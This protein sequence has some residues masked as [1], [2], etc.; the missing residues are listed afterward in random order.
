MLYSH[1]STRLPAIKKSIPEL[2]N[3]LFPRPKNPHEVLSTDANF[4]GEHLLKG[5]T[6]RLKYFFGT[7]NLLDIN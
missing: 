5:Y 7:I 4:Y 3:N 6:K 2:E 1:D